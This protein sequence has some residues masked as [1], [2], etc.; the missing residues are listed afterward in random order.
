[1]R[2]WCV[3]RILLLTLFE[4]GASA[5]VRVTRLDEKLRFADGIS[6]ER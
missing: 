4:A 1:M 6:V 3:L 5:E 2:L